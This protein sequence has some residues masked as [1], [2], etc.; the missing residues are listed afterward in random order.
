MSYQE[1]LRTHSYKFQRRPTDI[2]IRQSSLGLVE[3]M[4]SVP[5]RQIYISNFNEYP[6]Q[7]LIKTDDQLAR[8]GIGTT[9]KPEASPHTGYLGG[10]ERS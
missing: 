6:A 9:I 8:S 4:A 7:Q 1:L 3:Y 5:T 2:P 10:L